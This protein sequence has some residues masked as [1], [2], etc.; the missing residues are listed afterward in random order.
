M[1]RIFH[2][3]ATPDWDRAEARGSYDIDTLSSEGFI[4]CST[5]RQVIEVANRIFH[6]RRDLVLLCIDRAKVMAEIKDENCEDGDTLYPHIYGELNVDA[7]VTVH[8]FLP[9][10]DGSFVLP[11]TIQESES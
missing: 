9:E 3:A 1:N 6:G 2:I 11:E 10:Q 5:I 4:H 8:K 7:I